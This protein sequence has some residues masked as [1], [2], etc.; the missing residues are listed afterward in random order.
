MIEKIKEHKK[1]VEQLW[2][3]GLV[4]TSTGRVQVLNEPLFHDLVEEYE[5]RKR[6]CD[7]F[8]YEKI[9]VVDGVE[10]VYLMDEEEYEKSRR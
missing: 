10:V 7:Y 8:S 2:E 1:A 5:V 9:G 4:V 6:D 3:L